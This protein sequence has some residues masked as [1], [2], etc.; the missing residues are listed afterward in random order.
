MSVAALAA[1]QGDG[2]G[3][4]K[5]GEFDLVL[6]DIQM[7]E[8]DGFEATAAIRHHKGAQAVALPIVAMTAHA[9]QG[10]RDGACKPGWTPT[11]PSRSRLGNCGR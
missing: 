1:P 5:A 3:A 11:W 8:M 4:A 7:P 10:D 2:P 9:M 6:M